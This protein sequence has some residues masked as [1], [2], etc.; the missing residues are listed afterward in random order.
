MALAHRL[1]SP[2][3]DESEPEMSDEQIET[4]GRGRVYNEDFR[5]GMEGWESTLDML[6][7]NVRQWTEPRSPAMR[8]RLAPNIKPLMMHNG[9]I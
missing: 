3:D 4:N 1:L 5:F 6:E 9:A 2:T 8:K 7:L